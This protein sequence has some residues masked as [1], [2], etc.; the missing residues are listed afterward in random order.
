VF[1]DEIHLLL[2][3]RLSLRR[4]NIEICDNF[5]SMARKQNTEIYGTTQTARKVD[6]RFRE[7][8]DYVYKVKKYAYLDNN[9]FDIDH[10]VSFG[11][12]VP[13]R[14]YCRVYSL[15]EEI[16]KLTSVFTLDANKCYSLYDTYE[17][18]KIRNLP[19]LTAKAKK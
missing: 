15:Q 19:D 6:I 17:I 4:I 5:L 11:P 8:A 7:E 18:I 14:I 10:N 1:I 12:E 9:W 16:P 2:P 3:A 13:V